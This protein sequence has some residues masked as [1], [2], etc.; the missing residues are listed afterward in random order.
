MALLIGERIY[1]LWHMDHAAIIQS[2]DE[3]IERLQRARSLLTG[4]SDGVAPAR[5]RG[6]MSLEGRAKIAAASKA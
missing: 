1:N 4:H 3:A 6:T 5:K 2:I